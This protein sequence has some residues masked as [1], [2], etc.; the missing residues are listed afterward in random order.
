MT[1]Y[2]LQKTMASAQ[3]AYDNML[4]EDDRVITHC[5]DCGRRVQVNPYTNET[6]CT[7]SEFC[8]WIAEEK[9]DVL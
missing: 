9:D 7:D 6:E 2:N 8:G 4:P 1:N 3:R 5:P